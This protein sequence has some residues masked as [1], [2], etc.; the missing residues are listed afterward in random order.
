ML[1]VFAE[2][3]VH[4]TR[5]IAEKRK[6]R[7]YLPQTLRDSQSSGNGV[8]DEILKDLITELMVLKVNFFFLFGIH[9]PYHK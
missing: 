3:Q 5:H 6:S 2:L 1:S 9:E 8:W 7:G 4:Q